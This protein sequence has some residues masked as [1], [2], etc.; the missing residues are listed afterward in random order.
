MVGDV[1]LHVHFDFKGNLLDFSGARSSGGDVGNPNLVGMPNRDARMANAKGDIHS[2]EYH[3][4]V[5]MHEFR[6]VTARVDAL[7]TTL[8][9]VNTNLTN[10][11]TLF[12]QFMAHYASTVS[13]TTTAGGATPVV[14][15]LVVPSPLVGP[16]APLQHR[17]RLC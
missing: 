5:D 4:L 13:G 6:A 1:P 17:K 16:S 14:T 9:T 15:P 11:S 3:G 7:E 10:L 8:N 12:E 2:Q